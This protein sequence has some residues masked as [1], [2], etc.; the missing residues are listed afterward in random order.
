MASAEI[1]AAFTLDY[2]RGFHL[3]YIHI[4]TCVFG[5]VIHL[6]SKLKL[7]VIV[8]ENRGPTLQR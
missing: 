3:T 1:D 8:E 6:A 2:Q 4:P 5:F 7:G